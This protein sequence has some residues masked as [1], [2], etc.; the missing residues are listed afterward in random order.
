M[1][2]IR[3]SPLRPTVPTLR[4]A[5]APRATAR[6]NGDATRVRIVDAA[7]A[8]FG[9]RTF[10]T[11]SLREITQQAGVTL[12]LASYHFGSKEN[13]FAQTVARRADI[14]NQIRRAELKKL[15]PTP[16]PA[17]CSMRSCG[18]CLSG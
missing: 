3:K 1:P 13:L 18:R 17:T 11:V 10:D 4:K 15:R 2:K 7:E 14:L 16:R 8:L 6:A 9:E 12:A 5:P